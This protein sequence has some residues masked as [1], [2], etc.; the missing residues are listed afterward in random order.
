MDV[1]MERYDW[2]T[3]HYVTSQTCDHIR[4]EIRH[5]PV[6]SWNRFFAASQHFLPD[7]SG[8]IWTRLEGKNSFITVCQHPSETLNLVLVFTLFFSTNHWKYILKCQ[9][10]FIW[11]WKSF[12]LIQ[13]TL[14]P[15]EKQG[16]FGVL[17]HVYDKIISFHCSIFYFKL[18]LF[19]YFTTDSQTDTNRQS[20]IYTIYSNFHPP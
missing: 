7:L 16:F 19:S 14:A 2:W 1:W 3:T 9:N 6:L 11:T 18:L 4:K 10:V 20:D 12:L 17:T 5:C 8:N 13:E 15:Q